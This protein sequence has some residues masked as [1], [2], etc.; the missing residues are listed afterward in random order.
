MKNL[1]HRNLRRLLGTAGAVWVCHLFSGYAVCLFRFS[2]Y[3]APNLDGEITLGLQD[4]CFY[5]I[6][7]MMAVCAVWLTERPEDQEREVQMQ[8]IFPRKS[9]RKGTKFVLAVAGGVYAAYAVGGISGFFPFLFLTAETNRIFYFTAILC[10]V[11]AVCTLY[12]KNGGELF[13]QENPPEQ[14]EPEHTEHRP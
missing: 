8:L 14:S 11:M 7:I 1:R 3:L 13:R 5:I 4:Y 6:C 2:S 9:M 12:V 10:V